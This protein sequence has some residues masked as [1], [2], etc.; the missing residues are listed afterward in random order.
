MSSDPTPYVQVKPGDVISADLFNT[1]QADIKTDIAQQIATSIGGITT[2]KHAGDADTLAGSTVD[3]LS[4]AIVE[5][6]KALIPGRTGY[7]QTFN[8][9]EL[10]REKVIKHGLAAM[11]VVDVYQIEYFPV[12]QVDDANSPHDYTELYVNFYL[13]HESEQSFRLRGRDPVVIEDLDRTPFRLLLKDVLVLYNVDTS[14]DTM[15]LDELEANLWDA[16]FASP[17]DRFGQDQYARSPW[18]EK[19]CGEKRTIK[20]LKDDGH[21]DKLRL[22]FMPRKTIN[23]PTPPLDPKNPAGPPL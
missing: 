7:M 8:R 6:I 18:W 3:Q 23:W 9:L 14:K 11:P 10:N 1:V 20:D 5:R 22:K 16:L 13:Y 15:T 4:A 2:V 19:C 21:W 12:V 17:S